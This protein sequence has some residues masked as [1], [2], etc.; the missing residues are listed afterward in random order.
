MKYLPKNFNA[1][2][3]KLR[4]RMRCKLVYHEIFI[5]NKQNFF[6]IHENPTPP[7]L[8]RQN[9]HYTVQ[10]K[11]IST[12]RGMLKLGSILSF[13]IGAYVDHSIPIS[14][15]LVYWQILTTPLW[16][17][18]RTQ[19]WWSDMNQLTS[20]LGIWLVQFDCMQLFC[21]KVERGERSSVNGQRVNIQAV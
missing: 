2:T 1:H 17:S 4:Q 10:R 7:P 9:T 13:T 11:L 5:T 15:S 6:I 20:G 19:L 14:G 3:V 8:L 16:L 18:R 21:I 12:A